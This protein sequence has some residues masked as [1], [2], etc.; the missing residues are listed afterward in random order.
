MSA[1]ASR[2]G[3]PPLHVGPRH[4]SGQGSVL[5]PG[6]IQQEREMRGHQPAG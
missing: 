6:L 1:S 2:I 4:M 5:S 3:F